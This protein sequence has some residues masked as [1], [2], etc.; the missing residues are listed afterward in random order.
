MKTVCDYDIID[1]A[2]MAMDEVTDG[3]T[4]C[5]SFFYKDACDLVKELLT[6]ELVA[7]ES[8]ELED[9]LW[10]GYQDEYLITLTDEGDKVALSCEKLKMKGRDS[11][12]GFDADT[13]IVGSDVHYAVIQNNEHPEAETI[14]VVLDEDCECEEEDDDACEENEDCWDDCCEE[15]CARDG[16]GESSVHLSLKVDG[17]ELSADMTIEQLCALLYLCSLM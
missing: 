3:K 8:I 12:L 2:L 11:Y 14:E 10:D 5:L 15:C 1:V 9:P 13:L 17:E 6:Y 4:V 16:A 7:I